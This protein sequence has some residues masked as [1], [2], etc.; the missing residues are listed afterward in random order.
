MR[1]GVASGPV[2]AGVIGEQRLQFDLWG[3]TVNLASRMES[4]GVPGRI[5]IARSTRELLGDRFGLEARE[6]DVKGLGRQV[7]Y[8]VAP[9]AA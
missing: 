4:S 3:E 9:H 2:I 1:V 8:L 6:T 5:Q 7:T